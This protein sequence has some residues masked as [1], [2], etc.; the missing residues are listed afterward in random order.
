MNK[1]NYK[2]DPKEVKWYYDWG[3]LAPHCPA[4]DELAYEE[5]R[6]VFC[7][8]PFIFTEK[9]EPDLKVTGEIFWAVM[10][11]QNSIYVFELG[12]GALVCHESVEG[13]W[14]EEKLKQ[15]L[16]QIEEK[17]EKLEKRCYNR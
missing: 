12:T 15:H 2:N 1:K 11:S 13:K 16:T 3:V 8:Q 6:C 5:D 4:C 14:D 17:W 9:P 7:G 10:P